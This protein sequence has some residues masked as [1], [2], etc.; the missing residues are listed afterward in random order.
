MKTTRK[1]L[2]SRGVF[3]PEKKPEPKPEPEKKNISTMS[4]EV[5]RDKAIL[6]ALQDNKRAI[7][8]I[9]QVVKQQGAALTNMPKN[10]PSKKWD[11]SIHRDA[12]GFMTSLTLTNIS[13]D[14]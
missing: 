12:D 1:K 14:N 6:T 3:V 13:E 9:G 2:A 11:V 4:S 10:N 5:R 7:D 8:S